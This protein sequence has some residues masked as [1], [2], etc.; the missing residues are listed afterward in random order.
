MIEWLKRYCGPVSILILPGT[1]LLSWVS[2]WEHAAWFCKTNE[3]CVQGWF[4]ALSGWAAA[5]AAYFTIRTMNHQR[6][7]AT[8]YQ[9]ENVELE[10]M[11][12]LALARKMLTILLPC[13]AGCALMMVRLS[14]E[15][16]DLYEIFSELPKFTKETREAMESP[17]IA[18]YAEKIGLNR[19]LMQIA[20]T[21]Q[22]PGI[23]GAAERF[24]RS[25][26][27]Y[28]VMNAATLIEDG[29][30]LAKQVVGWNAKCVSFLDLLIDDAMRFST[31]W[32]SKIEPSE[33]DD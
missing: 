18:E 13:K 16:A 10:I 33:E 4:S 21:E 6:A 30:S 9:R 11:G 17:I 32:A 25:M 31:R 15:D 22:I 1:V 27:L 23:L 5:L 29:R 14:S 24:R 12:R 2:P 8:R 7:E 3:P 20:P 26:N 19:S 28:P